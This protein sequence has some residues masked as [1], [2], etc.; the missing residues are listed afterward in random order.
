MRELWLFIRRHDVFIDITANLITCEVEL[1]TDVFAHQ[2]VLI[3]YFWPHTLGAIV[4]SY[5]RLRIT[6]R[7]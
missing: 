3:K 1:C 5:W 2:N 7:Q 6:S 4:L